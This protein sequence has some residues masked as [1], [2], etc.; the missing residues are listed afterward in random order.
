MKDVVVFDL[1]G[2]LALIEHRRHYV[3]GKK[4]KWREFF[5]ASVH[6]APNEP[7]IEV[8]RALHRT[9]HEIW[10]VSGRSDEV[11]EVTVLWLANHEV[12]YHHLIMRRAGDFT[13]D[14]ILKHSWLI[15]GIIPKERVLLVFDDRDRVV[16]MWRREGLTCAQVAPGDF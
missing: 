14:D 4:K 1:D 16:A 13:A 5:A 11:R 10:I 15:K 8:D 3:A 9:G 7:I 12:P 2:T 6:D